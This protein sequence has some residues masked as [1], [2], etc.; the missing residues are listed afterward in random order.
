MSKISLTPNASGTGTFT[1]ASPNSN[2][3]RTLTLP[4]A[5]GALLTADGVLTA[6]AGASVGDVGTYAQLWA[7]TTALRDHG[8]T[9]A[10]SGLKYSNV[11]THTDGNLDGASP[12]SP[13]GTWRLMGNT[14]YENQGTG[15]SA[16]Q[17]AQM[18]VWL[19]VS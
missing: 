5:D 8:T 1:I 4:D 15:G 11:T 13:A 10:G 7:S 2:T 18:S 12:Y 16:R 9:V 6:V 19:R 3:N 17:R 14:G